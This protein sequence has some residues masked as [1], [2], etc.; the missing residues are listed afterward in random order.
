MF[1]GIM[2]YFY[3]DKKDK[4]MNKYDPTDFKPRSK[5]PFNSE[6]NNKKFVFTKLNK[7]ELKA[8]N[9]ENS[10]I[11]FNEEIDSADD[12]IFN[13]S[14]L[15]H[16]HNKKMEET[17]YKTNEYIDNLTKIIVQSSIHPDAEKSKYILFVDTKK[18]INNGE[19]QEKNKILGVFINK[20]ANAS[21]D[22]L[23]I[24]KI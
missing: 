19:L 15:Y 16:H 5:V 8:N 10:G 13:G 9:I 1:S 21:E 12:I 4:E 7:S 11:I 23:L 20:H 6:Y 17:G 3:G 18:E 14:Q 24:G 2:S 22:N